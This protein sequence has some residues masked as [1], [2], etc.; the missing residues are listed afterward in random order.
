M[1]S[2]GF[3]SLGVLVGL[4]HENHE[5]LSQS[6]QDT[7][8]SLL[9]PPSARRGFWVWCCLG[10]LWFFHC[11]FCCPISFKHLSNLYH[12]L[13]QNTCK[14][15]NH[16]I[17]PMEDAFPNR[18]GVEGSHAAVLW[19]TDPWIPGTSLSPQCGLE[20]KPRTCSNH[21]HL[22]IF[23]PWNHA[24]F[25]ESQKESSQAHGCSTPIFRPVAEEKP[26]NR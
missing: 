20:E 21:F 3:W 5:A 15:K 4:H 12:W 23:I 1:C 17:F 26:R 25:L 7:V 13:E 14:T 24:W 19:P 9:L 11:C 18:H 16:V 22:C 8:T 2:N 10:S 6:D